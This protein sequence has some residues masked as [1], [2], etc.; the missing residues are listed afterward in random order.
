MGRALKPC[1]TPGCPTLV[2]RGRCTGCAGEADRR[3]GTRQQRGYGKAHTNRFRP[4]V[5]RKDPLCVCTD[6]ARTVTH[7]HG[8][9]CLAPSTVADHYPRDKRELQALGLDDNDPQYGR[10]LCKVC[11]DHHT[12]Q[13]QPGGWHASP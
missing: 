2:A 5:L 4:G 3:R 7:H 12:A 6:Q 1:S 8:P 10:G 9:Q 13:A 11:H